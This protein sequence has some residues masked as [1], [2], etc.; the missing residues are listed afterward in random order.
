MQG[1]TKPKSAFAEIVFPEY[2]IKATGGIVSMDTHHFGILLYEGLE[3]FAHL[4]REAEGA[5]F[6][7]FKGFLHEVAVR[8]AQIA[9]QTILVEIVRVL[10]SKQLRKSPRITISLVAPWRVYHSTSLYSAW[11]E[12]LTEDIS[13]TGM[14]LI[15][16]TPTEVPRQ[17][18][19]MVN[20]HLDAK[21]LENRTFDEVYRKKS[22]RTEGQPIKIR[23]TVKHAKQLPNGLT[24]FGVLFSK[25]ADVDRMRL[26]RFLA[27][28]AEENDMKKSA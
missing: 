13:A 2:G 26:L 1:T 8:F 17:I 10:Y 4:P 9:D 5:L 20:I 25:V 7:T 27:D 22:I 15:V 14:R 23:G 18:E 16:P 6:F 28:K 3:A 12:G 24:A 21:V 11:L 19:A